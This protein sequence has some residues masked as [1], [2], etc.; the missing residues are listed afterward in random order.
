MQKDYEGLLLFA[1]AYAL[2]EIILRFSWQSRVFLEDMW[3]RWQKDC[4][5]HRLV[6]DDEDFKFTFGQE[7][8]KEQDKH[9]TSFAS[10]YNLNREAQNEGTHTQES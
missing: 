10:K 3:G 9:F 4:I 5:L 7:S 8:K 1:R 6:K 2:H